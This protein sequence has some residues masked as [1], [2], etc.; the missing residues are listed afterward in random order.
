MTPTRRA[1]A[2]A[3]VV[4]VV[5]LQTLGTT[6]SAWADHR[7]HRRARKVVATTARVR[8]APTST[9]G[10]FYGTPVVIVRGNAPL[11]GGYSPNE[12]F[13]DQTLALYG[14][15]SAFRT[16]TAPMV[17]YVRGYDGRVSTIQTLT[18]S[19][20]NLPE[21]SSFIYPTTSNY[22]YGPRVNRTP[23]WGTNALNWIDQN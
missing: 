10:N 13:G 3:L 12:I 9:L 14:P 15:L 11:G 2:R 16:T 20:P 22:F 19:N 4:C 8:P 18:F 5:L 6:A 1:G 17:T 23:P 7:T 21:L